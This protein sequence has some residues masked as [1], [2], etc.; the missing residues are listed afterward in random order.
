MEE[1][2]FQSNDLAGVRVVDPFMG[3]GTP[4]IEANRVGCDV[5]GFDVNQMAAWI[6][7]EA[8]DGIDLGAYEKAAKRLAQGLEE[9]VGGYYRT[10][11][12]LYGDEDVPVKSFLWIKVLDCEGCGTQVDCFPGIWWRG[13]CGIRSRCFCALV[14]AN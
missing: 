14:A 12:V 7:R 6:V 13:T 11:C 1:A 2:F 8:S 4:L 5:E 9:E 10:R 3:G